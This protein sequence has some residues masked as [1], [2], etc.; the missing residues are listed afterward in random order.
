MYPVSTELNL[1]LFSRL[2]SLDASGSLCG[3]AVTDFVSTSMPTLERV[4]FDSCGS[5]D[6]CQIL[7]KIK[8]SRRNASCFYSIE[9]GLVFK[10]YH[11]RRVRLFVRRC[12]RRLCID[13]HA[14]ARAC[15]LRLVAI[16]VA[17]AA[18]EVPR[19]DEA[20]QRH[21]RR[22]AGADFELQALTAMQGEI[23]RRKICQTTANEQMNSEELS[24]FVSWKED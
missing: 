20:L 15:E 7:I 18:R 17:G 4:S 16:D 3:D 23:L 10:T 14:D 11:P 5:I 12:R 2:T 6:G 9:Y 19:V 1:L 21:G 24:C 13:E 8:A 22:H